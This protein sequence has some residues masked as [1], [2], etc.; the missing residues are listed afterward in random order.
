MARFPAW[1]GDL[2][3]ARRVFLVATVIGAVLFYFRW[4]EGTRIREVESNGIEAIAT[5]EGA[6]RTTRGTSESYTLRLVWRDAR[7]ITQS[8][9]NVR[10]S[11]AFAREIFSAGK[12]I[13][14]TVRI[15]YLP[16]SMPIVLEDASYR[17]WKE[18]DLV[19]WLGAGIACV[20]AVGFGVTAFMLGRRRRREEAT[21]A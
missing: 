15:K 20:G 5:V 11:N 13:R 7:G 8:D 18:E 2:R 4:A 9:E 19:G 21:A 16:H 17:Q 6:T 10:I 14:S 12:I 1:I 3:Q